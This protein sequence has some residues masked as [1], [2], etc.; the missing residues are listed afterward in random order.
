MFAYKS[1]VRDTESKYRDLI[2]KERERI[3]AA[4]NAALEKAQEKIRELESSL[5]A[6]NDQIKELLEQANSDPNANNPSLGIDSVRRINR[7]R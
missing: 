1:G 5:R 3:E 4:N 7:I 2:L 6:R